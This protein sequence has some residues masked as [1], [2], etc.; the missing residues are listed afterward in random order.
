MMQNNLKQSGW[1]RGYASTHTY[2]TSQLFR[3]G[4]A[5]RCG[6][7]Y[8]DVGCLAR[9]SYRLEQDPLSDDARSI[10]AIRDAE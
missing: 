1:P 9:F 10:P 4:S 2:S 3:A 5:S 7:F 8:Q 6:P